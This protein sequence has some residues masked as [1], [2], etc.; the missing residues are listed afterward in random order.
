[1]L[2]SWIFKNNKKLKNW[3]FPLYSTD[4]QKQHSKQYIPIPKL[5]K[6]L[7]FQW[8]PKEDILY[9]MK[10]LQRGS[11]RHVSIKHYYV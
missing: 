4:G 9:V 8:L 7:F 11:S 3:I 6:R 2:Q 5:D 10:Q 1:M